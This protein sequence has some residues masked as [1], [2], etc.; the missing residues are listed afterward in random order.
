VTERFTLTTSDGESLEARWDLAPTPEGVV[1]FCHPHPLQGGSMMAPLMIAVTTR[2]VERGFSV[3]RFNFRG[4]GASSGSHEGG[5]GELLDLTAAVAAASSFGVNLNMAGWSFGAG[6]ALNWLSRQAGPVGYVGIAPAAVGLP[7]E[8]PAGPKR[9][10]VGYRDQVVNL[11]ELRRYA[12]RQHIDLL[13]V[14]GDHFFHGRGKRI[15]DLVAQG[16]E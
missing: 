5:E 2:L 6:I 11:D 15:G 8:L 16:F 7:E 14:P 13:M 12:E 9:I 1:V 4:T 3:L 10:V